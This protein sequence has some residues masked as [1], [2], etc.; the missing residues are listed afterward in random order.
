MIWEATEADIPRIL[1]MGSD[2][3]AAA[4]WPGGTG[5]DEDRVK[6]V[7][8]RMIASDEAVIF[9]SNHGMLGGLLYDHHFFGGLMAQEMFWF[10]ERNGVDL[11]RSFEGWA[12]Q[13]GASAILM[14]NMS[15]INDDRM[16][17]IYARLGYS[18]TERHYAKVI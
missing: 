5:Y 14:A 6:P 13:K 9:L 15:H 10:A 12:R 17:K 18:P 8:E 7:I 4:R 16:A 11:L 3:I 1:D 2:F